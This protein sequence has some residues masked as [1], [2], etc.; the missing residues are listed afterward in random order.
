[1]VKKAIAYSDHRMAE[2]YQ[3]LAE[4]QIRSV[5]THITSYQ[6]H[7]LYARSFFPEVADGRQYDKGIPVLQWQA[8]KFWLE[9][10][11][12]LQAMIALV[13][14]PAR[15]CATASDILK[16]LRERSKRAKNWACTGPS[17]EAGYSWS[18]APVETQAIL[19]EAFY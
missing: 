8:K 13:V 17:N 6:I 14:Q 2:D 3:E 19:I 11:L 4:A 10:S 5:K 9:N 12:S 1:M 16:S 15:R 7:Y 18:Q